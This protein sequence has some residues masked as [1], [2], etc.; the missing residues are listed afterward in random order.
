MK[1]E[2]EKMREEVKRVNEENSKKIEMIY[3]EIVKKK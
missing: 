3:N 1:E 2:N